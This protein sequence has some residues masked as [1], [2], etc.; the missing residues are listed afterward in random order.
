MFPIHPQTQIL[1]SAGFDPALGCPE[2]EQRVFIA[3]KD[4]CS[5]RMTYFVDKVS[6]STFAHMAHSL[7]GL[8]NGRLM[9][10]LEGGYF[11]PSLAGHPLFLR[12]VKGSKPKKNFFY[13]SPF[14]MHKLCN[15]KICGGGRNEKSPK[16][17]FRG[18]R[19]DPPAVIGSSMSKDARAG[20]R[21]LRDEGGGIFLEILA[22]SLH[23]RLQSKGFRRA[24]RPIGDASNT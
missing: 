19:S 2:G 9:A 13:L 20:S 7:A 3:F 10:L 1:V 15:L 4:I 16:L 21:F 18:R 14:Q 22:N 6:P 23:S 12:C 24:S 5:I 17:H 8:A 11:L